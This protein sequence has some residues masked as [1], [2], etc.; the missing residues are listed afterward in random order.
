MFHTSYIQSNF[1]R[2]GKC[3]QGRLCCQIFVPRHFLAF[4]YN[5]IGDYKY[6][7]TPRRRSRRDREG[8]GRLQIW[9]ALFLIHCGRKICYRVFRSLLRM[10]Q[11]FIGAICEP[12]MGHFY[13]WVLVTVSSWPCDDDKRQRHV[14]SQFDSPVYAMCPCLTKINYCRISYPRLYGISQIDDNCKIPGSCKN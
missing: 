10:C 6:L 4:A 11:L 1:S 2:K 3:K 12:S 8:Q 9:N 14:N 5:L 7:P 13:S